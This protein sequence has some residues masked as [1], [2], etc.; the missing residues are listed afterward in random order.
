MTH[1]TGEDRV[2]Y[3]QADHIF[4]V[5]LSGKM[6]RRSV[7]DVSEA[8][9]DCMRSNIRGQR[10][11]KFLFDFRRVQWDSEATHSEARKISAEYLQEFRGYHYVSAILNDQ[12]EGR[13]FEKEC[14]FTREQE[15]LDW[16]RRNDDH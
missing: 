11:I 3:I 13:S 16:L 1:T 9:K 10:T 14:F 2:K 4:R 8:L 7:C 12:R 5:D 15:A 6:D